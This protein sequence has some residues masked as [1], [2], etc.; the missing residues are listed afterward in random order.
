[1][2]FGRGQKNVSNATMTQWVCDGAI[3]SSNAFLNR[4]RNTPGMIMF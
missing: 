4:R 1:M 3:A 2:K